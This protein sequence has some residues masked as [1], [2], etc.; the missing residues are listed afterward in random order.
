MDGW[1]THNSLAP[2]LSF[3]QLLSVITWHSF[4]STSRSDGPYPVC[5]FFILHAMRCSALADFTIS[6]S[7]SWTFRQCMFSNHVQCGF[8]P[9]LSGVDVRNELVSNGF[10]H[11][12]NHFFTNFQRQPFHHL[13]CPVYQQQPFCSSG[14]LSPCFTGNWTH[15]HIISHQLALSQTNIQKFTRT[16]LHTNTHREMTVFPAFQRNCTLCSAPHLSAHT[17]LSESGC[18][19]GEDAEY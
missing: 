3:L 6:I 2:P 11:S 8:S 14:S 19:Y 1:M 12:S 10:Y 16:C 18:Y 9:P 4:A 7:V 15:T 17:W 13:P 5:V